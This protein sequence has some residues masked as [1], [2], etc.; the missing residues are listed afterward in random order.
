MLGDLLYTPSSN[1]INS[2][3]LSRFRI[4]INQKYN[5]SLN[6]YAELLEWSITS[7]A[8]FW[9]EVWLFT[10]VIS[11]TPYTL[12]SIFEPHTFLIY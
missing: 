11:S 1:L 2:S 6:S 3:A 7:T 8:D 4:G 5:L 12:V 10:E 9:K